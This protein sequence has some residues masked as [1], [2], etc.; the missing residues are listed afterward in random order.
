MR[1]RVSKT[2]NRIPNPCYFASASVESERLEPTR[3]S[4]LLS[5]VSP[6]DDLLNMWCV[7][8]YDGSLY[9]GIVTEYDEEGVEVKSMSKV[10]ENR[11]FWPTRE[12]RIRYGYDKVLTLIPEPTRIGT[13]HVQINT[14]YWKELSKLSL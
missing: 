13:R 5:A 7:M 8:S 4:S 2:I 11:F 3:T 14:L 10:G 6:H 1:N 9:P 12:D